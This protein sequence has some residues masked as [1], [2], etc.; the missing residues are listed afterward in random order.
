VKVGMVH[1]PD[2]FNHACGL[3]NDCLVSV[4]NSFQ[5]LHETFQKKKK[6]TFGE[7]K[8]HVKS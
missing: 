2:I 4:K 8:M 5:L 3:I 7:I 6:K 1:F